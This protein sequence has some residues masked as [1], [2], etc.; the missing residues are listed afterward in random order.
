V[1]VGFWLTKLKTEPYGLDFGLVCANHCVGSEI[2][3]GG[4]VDITGDGGC[5]QLHCDCSKQNP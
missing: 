2:D 3:M 4:E 1:G 5:M